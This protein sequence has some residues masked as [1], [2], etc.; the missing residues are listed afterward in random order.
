MSTEHRDFRPFESMASIDRYLSEWRILVG[1]EAVPV[2]ARAILEDDRYLIANIDLVIPSGDHSFDRMVG[3]MSADL[4]RIDL[5]IDDLGFAVNLSTS[6]L[7]ISEYVHQMPFRDLRSAPSSLSLTEGQ[8]P[9]ALRAPR[10]GCTITPIV[11]L[12][13]E[14]ER[15]PRRPWRFGTWISRAEFVVETA[16][17]FSG[18]TPLPLTPELKTS[19]GLAQKTLRFVSLEDLNPLEPG[20]TEDSVKVYVDSSILAKLSAQP[21]SRGSVAFQ[22]QLFVDAV[23]A[24]VDGARS[25]DDFVDKSWDDVRDSLFGRV[26]E[27]LIPSKSEPT[28]RESAAAA[29]LDMAKQSQTRFMTFIEE[30]AGVLDSVDDQLET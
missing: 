23:T 10:S 15:A 1:G 13:N 11:Y 22:R 18:F 8:R 25:E 12:R 5:T 30:V 17:A 6:F 16:R 9:E 27:L 24:I 19:M 2:G 26:V 3:E 21:K 29:Y 28:A 20:I 7:K 4:E 14:K